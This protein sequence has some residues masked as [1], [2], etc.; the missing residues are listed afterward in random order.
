[1]EVGKMNDD[2]KYLTS[3]EAYEALANAIVIQA[4]KDYRK[5]L[6]RLQKHPRN[7]MALGEKKS[8]LNFFKS[9]YFSILTNIDS[10]RLISRV[11]REVLSYDS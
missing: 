9:N 8:L 11:E 7:S 10:G 6:I 5:V 1:M 3:Q 4:V 2:T